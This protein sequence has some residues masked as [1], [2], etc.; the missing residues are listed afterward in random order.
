MAAMLFPLLNQS[1]WSEPG[2]NRALGT[3][4][5][6]VVLAITSGL[7]ALTL[8]EHPVILYAAGAL[9]TLGVLL[10]LGTAFSVLW[11]T[12]LRQENSFQTRRQ[13]WAP[14]WAGLTLSLLLIGSIDLLR[15]R[16]TGTWGGIP[17]LTGA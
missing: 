4:D 7:D 10:L 15:Y 17:G 14:A 9:S 6:L 11:I 12:A 1:I 2:A 13:L 8:S 3:R 16:L 5:F